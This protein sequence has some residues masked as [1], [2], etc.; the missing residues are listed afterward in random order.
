MLR[1]ASVILWCISLSCSLL[2]GQSNSGTVRGTVL[3]PSG[4]AISGSIVGI[5]NPVSHYN[6]SALTD[7]QGHFEF[8]NVP[9]NNYHTTAAAQGFQTDTQ[10][11]DLRSTV[12]IDLKYSLKIGAAATTVTVEGAADLLQTDSTTRTDVDRALFDKLP[13]ES[14]SSSL[15]SL[16]TLASP[17]VAAD[18]NG[19]FHGLGDHAE[20]SFSIDGQP[21]TDQQSK[22]FSNQLPVDA[23]QSL[24]VIP[25]AP[26]PEFGGKT[27][28]VIVATTRSGLGNTTPHGDLTASYGTFGTTNDAF[29]LS[30]GG[31]NWGNFISISGLETGRF[32]DPPEFTVLHDKG[33][34]ENA[35]DR[36]DLKPTNSDTLSLNLQ[37]TRS[38]FQTPNTW[39]QQ[40]QTCTVVS[41]MCSG[42]PYAPGS[43]V[44][45]PLTG[46]P[47]GPTDQR[48]QI[49]TFDIAPSWS[50]VLNTS[51]VLTIG[52]WVRHDEYNYYP[53]PD[54]FSD[55]GPLQDE[56]FSQFRTLTNAG[57]R[58]DV[59]YV[60]G[61][62][63][64]K[65]G[66]TFQH[67][68]L[69]ENDTFGIV[70]PGLLAGCTSAACLTLA[71][72]DL[73]NPATDPTGAEFPYHGHTDIK[74][75]A[76]YLQDTITKGPWSIMIG[77]RGDFY[78]G[79][80]ASS[81]QPEPRA[82]IAYDI[83][84][85]GTVL[86]ISYARTMESPFNENL[87]ITSTGCTVPQVAAVMQ[88]A[89][90]FPCGITSTSGATLPLQPLRP[91]FRNE[92]HAGLEQAFGKHFVL[93][94]E[95]LWRYTHNAYDFNILGTSPITLP[96][97]WA[98][99]KI[100][101]YAIRGSFP[102]WHGLTAFVVMSSV[103]ARFFPP[104]VS[105]IAP[106]VPPGVFRIDHDERFNQTTHIQ[107]QPFK[108]GPWLGFN[109]RYDSGLV[110]GSTPCLAPT[111]TC[112]F[113]TG[114]A[115]S[116]IAVYSNVPIPQ[117][118][119]L[120][121]S[122]ATGLPLTADQEFQ[123]GLTCGGMKATPTS[124]IGTQIPG[125][126]GFYVCPANQLTSNLVKIPAPGTE[127]DDHN[128]QRIQPR[129]LFDMALGHD[130]IFH[131]DRYKFSARIEVINLTDKVALYNF[132]STFSGTHYVSPRTV[133]GTIGFHF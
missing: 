66:G 120:L 9:F 8:D 29:D 110:A 21:I 26:P 16:V 19:L 1:S 95:Y 119:I 126:P 71:P 27:S 32:L 132:L 77:I 60:K 116:P 87:I 62:H 54:L 5:E 33:N 106:S 97:E 61:I 123:S 3:D 30:Y 64:I 47:L 102:T 51:T 85:T 90:G 131:G 12:P 68:F 83:K 31:R 25:G 67:T 48:S 76:L 45:N 14:Q 65:L 11:I 75:S 18:S 63:N 34:Q 130:N 133:T 13:L 43:V 6:R 91:G 74:E 36:F 94:G 129:N 73:T 84:K 92:F 72:Y 98:K 15:S 93:S 127:N 20:N 41:A 55:L 2:H 112:S 10:D 7:S 86:R 24:E 58:A 59:T 124:P 118:D 17:G 117:G 56:T 37:F 100:P 79:L 88:I 111:A 28:L 23:V 128:P 22:V 115:D 109:W 122:A 57:L 69:T 80:Q 53:S 96:I 49:R 125:Y 113:S 89:Q 46:N 121:N 81:Q 103:A 78:Y 105:G 44:L 101:G 42:A 114:A 52:A 35:F 50:R 104:T 70:N 38:W 39:D 82:G 99:S 40:L 108:R 4:A 107:Y